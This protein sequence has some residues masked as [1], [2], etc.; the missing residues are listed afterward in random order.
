MRRSPRSGPRTPRGPF[1]KD[2]RQLTNARHAS[3][4]T[5]PG[6]PGRAHLRPIGLDSSPL[7]GELLGVE[8]LEE[9]ARA[10][11]AEF[12][13]ARN[14]RH[15]P[16]RLLRRLAED[17]RVLRAAYRALAGDVRRGEPG[18]PAA[19][20]LLDNFHLIEN[21]LRDI[22]RD[23]PTRYYLE[24]PKLAARGRAG[25]PRVYAMAVELL[26][27]SDARLDALRLDRFINAYQTVAPLTIGELWAWPSMLKLALLV[28]LRRLSEEL[29]ESRAGRRDADRCFAAFEN[30]RPGV[31]AP[32]L[33][34]SLHVAFVDQ[35]LQRMR[36]SGAGA[37]E[38]R[39][40][41]EQRLEAAG[42]TVEDAV[43]AEHQRLA[44][45]HLSMGN[46]ITSLRLCSTIDWNEYVENVS[47]IEQILR[48]DPAALYSRMDFT[49]RDRY[50]H[51]V[52][53]L[54]EPSGEAQVRV[55]LRAVESARQA[56]E[57]PG[58]DSRLAH[59]GYHL[60]GGGRHALEIDVAHH[61][62]LLR[63]LQRLALSHA[64]SFYLGAIAVLTG[65]GVA[66]AVGI[67]R[68]HAT[69][70]W[71]WVWVGAVALIPASEFAVALMQRLVHRLAHPVALPRLDLRGGVPEAA[72]TLV[73]VPTIITSVE[74]VATLVENLEVHALGNRDPY[75]HFALLTD[76]ADA[77]SE[78]LP[79]E[80]AVLAAAIAGIDGLN[81]R[82]APD[83]ADRFHLFHRARRWNGSEGVWMGW[84]RKRGKLEELNRLLRG[85][86]DT[87]FTVR[88]GDPEILPHIRYVITLD[89]DTRLPRDAAR[90][91]IGVIEHPLNRPRFDPRVGRVV[92][93]YGILQPRVSVTMAS[94]AGSLF[95]RA[96]AGH[97][98]VDP[99][100]TTVSDTYQDLFGEG[101][102]TGKGLYDVD[103]FSA[104][105][106][107]RVP[108][109]AMLSHD[110]FEGL[111]ARC[112]LVSDVEVVDDFPSSVLTHARRQHRWVRGDWQVLFCLL[113]VMPTRH[114]LERT[115]LPLISRWKV[116]DNLRRSLLAPA[117]MVL[118]A[119]AW[120]WLPGSPLG[121]T[122]AAL[123]MIA[124]PLVPPLVHLIG[125][126]RPQQP[127]GVFVHDVWSEFETAAAQMLL[128]VTLLAYH[129][130]EMVHAIVLTLVRMVFTQRR[131]LE[132]ETAASAAARATGLLSR[133]GLRVFV[134]EMWAGPAAALVTLLILLP[135]HGDALPVALPF[136]GA[137]LASPLIAWWLSRP[138]V[139]RRLTLGAA[140]T[141][142]L[143]RIARR[144]W[145]YF[146]R[147]VTAEDHHLPPDNV[148]QTPDLRVAHRTSPTNIGM[149]LLSTLAAYDL[150]YL[151][152]DQL[153]ARI[154]AT[155]THA[156]GSRASRGPPAQLV[157]HHEPRAAPA[158]VRL[159][160]GQ[161]K[162]GGRTHGT[163][164]RPS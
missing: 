98:G 139:P 141:E 86:T 7:H 99:Y 130:Y 124:F 120:T 145:H 83:K 10:L 109:N 135:S 59:V 118:L 79:G 11:A 107:G 147:F 121:W 52:E 150:G 49:S 161:W 37:A 15:G 46:S 125:G 47:L 162:S 76:F 69:P 30:A 100:T 160:R 55:A 102:F 85:A 58:A 82:Y 28:H 65:L 34:A 110:L 68:A 94:A 134:A 40:Q 88:R 20:W 129:A 148:Q 156:R 21:E 73:V 72:R 16:P 131:L 89:S 112:A 80:D 36:E 163:G 138:V 57:V 23:L 154:E 61:P 62:P 27:Y 13:L 44:M 35:L 122:L 151:R 164:R 74:S 108:E 54:A 25:T 5:T 128:Q 2:G 6:P 113:P 63:R 133:H 157:R 140:D 106:A 115:N 78:H 8:R 90:R 77:I 92:E 149:G 19:E 127:V 101:S 116:L 42:A 32:P 97:T 4:R 45:N 18:T 38:L 104:A 70:Q 119:S 53:A 41:L 22:R 60:I 117:L 137:W 12:T 29:L 155:L 1:R 114:G 123:A 91:L 71:V 158:A 96:Y 87:S 39:K 3:S 144:T 56:A 48:R 126:P 105:L 152:G 111:Y 93:G 146:E 95:A 153:A 26:R 64:T 81:A 132:W 43:R 67:A 159:D 9:R 24:L 75:I 103:T 50:R 84:E 14:P 51:A 31:S 143:R 17:A 136:V 66:G 33:P 142:Q